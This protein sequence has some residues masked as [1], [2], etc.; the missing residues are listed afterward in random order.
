MHAARLSSRAMSDR[1]SVLV[2]TGPTGV[3][4]SAIAELIATTGGLKNGVGEI[5]SADS[6]QVCV[7]LGSGCVAVVSL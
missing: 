5:I 4:K 1:P 6:A 2:I 7:G 3:G